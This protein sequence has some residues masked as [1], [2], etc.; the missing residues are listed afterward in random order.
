MRNILEYPITLTELE[1]CLLQQ[2]EEAQYAPGHM[3]NPE[4]LLIGG[5]APLILRLA[6]Q[7]CKKAITESRHQHNVE[8]YLKD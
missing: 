6:A 3:G 5:T 7:I 1:E 8:H 2:S 4:Y